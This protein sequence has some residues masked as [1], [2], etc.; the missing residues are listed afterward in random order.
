MPCSLICADMNSPL[1]CPLCYG[2][3]RL[4]VLGVALQARE[5]C[6]WVAG[7]ASST[8]ALVVLW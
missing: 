3:H 5:D 6:Q 7:A 4:G 1:H 8:K 2:M